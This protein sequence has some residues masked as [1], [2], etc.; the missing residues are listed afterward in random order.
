MDSHQ[1]AMGKFSVL[2]LQGK[3]IHSHLPSEYLKEYRDTIHDDDV[4]R[5][6]VHHPSKSALPG[7]IERIGAAR[8]YPVIDG[9]IT[10]PE[11]GTVCVAGLTLEEAARKIQ[12]EYMGSLSDVEVFLSYAERRSKRVELAGLVAVSAIPTDGRPP[13]LGCAGVRKSST[14]G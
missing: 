8:G 7:S 14:W 1:L 6:M 12:D 10:L 3:N 13:P 4:L 2:D 9:A 11:L 5:I